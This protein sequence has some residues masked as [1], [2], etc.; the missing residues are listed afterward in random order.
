MCSGS[1]EQMPLR[2]SV[3]KSVR[4]TAEQSPTHERRAGSSLVQLL[5]MRLGP[6]RQWVTPERE[7]C[8]GQ[9]SRRG[10]HHIRAC[11]HC[12]SSITCPA[13][14]RAQAAPLPRAMPGHP[15]RASGSRITGVTR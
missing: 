13:E 2:C 9:R 6:I 3:A 1:E 7:R 11:A 5:G 14:Q 12:C 4:L 8:G 10:T 15:G